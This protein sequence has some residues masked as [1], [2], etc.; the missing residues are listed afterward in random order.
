[1]ATITDGKQTTEQ[2]V[3]SLRWRAYI[4][5]SG[6]AVPKSIG[7]MTLDEAREILTDAEVTS[8]RNKV[9]R[10]IDQYHRTGRMP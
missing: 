6:L 5:L 7:L 8:M 10:M 1:M 9:Q 2:S 3:E 4:R